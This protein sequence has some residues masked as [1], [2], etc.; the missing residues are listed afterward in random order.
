MGEVCMPQYVPRSRRRR[1][2]VSWMLFSDTLALLSS[3]LLAA[4]IRFG[5]V[6]T[7]ASFE[8]FTGDLNYFELAG[9]VTAIWLGALWLGGTYDLERTFWGSGEFSRVFRS[10]A[11]GVVGFIVSTYIVKMPGLSRAWTLLAFTFSVILVSTGR[12]LIRSVLRSARRKRRFMRRAIVVGCNAEGCDIVRILDK[13]PE[14]GVAVCGLLLSRD[15]DVEDTLLFDGPYPI[16]GTARE[17]QEVVVSHEIDTVIVASSAF[18]HDVVSRIVNELRGM[19]VTIHV[20]SGLFEIL[21]SRVMV[22]EVAGVPLISV[23]SVTFSASQRRTKR[24]FDL[25]GAGLIILGGLPLWLLLVLAIKL[26]SRG[27]VFYKQRRVGRNGLPFDMFKFRSMCVDA[28]ARLEELAELNEATGPLF[29]IKD[30][31]RVTRMGKWMRKFSVDEFPQ[32]L[33]V[34]KGEM[35]LVGPRPPLPQE[36]A[37][38]TEY[39]W[40][41]MEVP[42]G[43]TGLWQVSG[44][45]T[46]T[47]DEMV[48]LDLF[49]IENWTVGFDLA[50]LM[51]T[52]PAV[53]FADGAY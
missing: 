10:L 28:D 50:L 14:S 52:V 45:S 48:R 53:L 51:R 30:D 16:L 12:L 38:Y 31:P 2:L 44:R 23:R 24:L 34:M 6:E 1:T 4:W 9:F 35:S 26:D 20:S 37:E 42:P 11:L 7:Q 21:T 27:P 43:M 19:D 32:L 40:R 17:V 41:R 25:A 18:N 15:A 8:N 47:F 49:Y 46:L 13:H 3:A 5:S 22:R 33:N 36:T 39:D 29:K